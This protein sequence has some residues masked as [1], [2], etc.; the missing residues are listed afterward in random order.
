MLSHR[1][2]DTLT[3]LMLWVSMLAWCHADKLSGC[4]ADIYCHTGTGYTNMIT[5]C[6]AEMREIRSRCRASVLTGSE[7]SS[8]RGCL[9]SDK[10]TPLVHKAMPNVA[11]A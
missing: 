1:P 11:I 6:H 10:H 3:W 9:T 5:L 7:A 8:G 4:R 2:A